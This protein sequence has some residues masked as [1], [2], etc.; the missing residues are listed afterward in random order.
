MA[1]NK[2]IIKCPACGEDMVKVLIP[3]LN[4]YVDICLNGCGGMLFDNRELEKIDEPHENIDDILTAIKEKS[5]KEVDIKKTRIC[6]LCDIPM[7]KLGEQ[8]DVEIDVCN[9]CGA[10]FLDNGELQKLRALASKQ[11]NDNIIWEEYMPMQIKQSLGVR[12]ATWIAT[13][14]IKS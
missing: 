12:A 10:K 5:F 4:I 11:S 14:I 1:D 3:D 2:E 8:T 13:N 9:M 7:V 6:P